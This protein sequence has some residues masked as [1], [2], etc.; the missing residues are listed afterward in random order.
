MAFALIG[1]GQ[2]L[3]NTVRLG[4]FYQRNFPCLGEIHNEAAKFPANYNVIVRQFNFKPVSA[5][6]GLASLTL[7]VTGECVTHDKNLTEG[8]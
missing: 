2:N 5:Q 3:N 1:K 8:G 7:T 6:K 4:G